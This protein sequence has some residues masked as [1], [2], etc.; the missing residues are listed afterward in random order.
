VRTRQRLAAQPDL[1]DHFNA[2][3]LDKH[4][5]RVCVEHDR[6][7]RRIEKGAAAGPARL[8]RE[9]A[10]TFRQRLKEFLGDSLASEVRLGG[11]IR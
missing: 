10:N 5:E 3:D 2:G 1:S 7:V 9:H 11:Q 6:T 4:L 8:G